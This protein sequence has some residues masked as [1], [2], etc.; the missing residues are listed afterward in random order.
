MKVIAGS[1]VVLIALCLSQPAMA[2]DVPIAIT[3]D[4]R[5]KEQLAKMPPSERKRAEQMIE[6][7]NK[8]VQQYLDQTVFRF[9]PDYEKWSRVTGPLMA[10]WGEDWERL[11]DANWGKLKKIELE[12]G[13][14]YESRMVCPQA[15]LLL[16]GRT[17]QGFS[18][19]YGSIVMGWEMSRTGSDADGFDVQGAGELFEVG[20]ELNSSNRVAKFSPADGFST[21]AYTLSIHH[22]REF[23]RKPQREGMETQAYVNAKV[24][25]YQK[26]IANMERQA[27]RVCK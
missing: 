27:E 22:M 26:V 4:I 18:L 14:A 16:L 3:V 13:I 24:A 11:Y 25:R 5:V 7:G 12:N 6:V 15:S 20:I 9:D 8:F 1:L 10:I 21:A 23:I 17:E 2:V 19:R